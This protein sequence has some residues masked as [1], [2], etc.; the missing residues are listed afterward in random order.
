MKYTCFL[1]ILVLMWIRMS[2]SNENLY[3]EEYLTGSIKIN[4][5]DEDTSNT[6]SVHSLLTKLVKACADSK[7]GFVNMKYSEDDHGYIVRLDK[8]WTH[9]DDNEFWTFFNDNLKHEKG[10]IKI[11]YKLPKH[12]FSIS[13]NN[14]TNNNLLTLISCDASHKQK[15]MSFLSHMKI[16]Y[17]YI[18]GTYDNDPELIDKFV[19]TFKLSDVHQI[20]NI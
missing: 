11:D 2:P 13:N 18:N 8:K 20:F 16:E 15:L 12:N 1:L 6:E 10:Y 7:D 17:N 9:E 3:I 19:N 4:L 14:N 5:K